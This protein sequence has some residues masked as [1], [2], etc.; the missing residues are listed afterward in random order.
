ML[1]KQPGGEKKQG[2]LFG[3]AQFE[4]PLRNSCRHGQ[5]NT[6]TLAF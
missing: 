5:S 3:S 4:I 6:E 2:F 1:V